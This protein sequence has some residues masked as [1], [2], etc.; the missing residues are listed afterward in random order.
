[1]QESDV[2]IISSY[3]LPDHKDS[4]QNRTRNNRWLSRVICNHTNYCK[5][6][7][8]DY[9][10]RPDSLSLP[11]KS[12]SLF[13][14]GANSK[15]GYILQA[16]ELG[17]KHVFWMDPD[18]LFCNLNRT[19]NDLIHSSSS[20]IASGDSHEIVNAGHLFF[21]SSE[22]SSLLLHAWIKLQD[23]KFQGCKSVAFD[24]T[25]EG[26]CVSDNT[27]L[28][29]LLAHGFEGI[30]SQSIVDS[31]NR[32]NGYFANPYA[33]IDKFSNTYRFHSEHNV[34]SP[35]PALASSL[36]DYVSILPQRRLNSYVLYGDRY[37]YLRSGDPIVHF[38]GPDKILLTNPALYTLYSLCRYFHVLF[39]FRALYLNLYNRLR[40]IHLSL[41]S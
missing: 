19:L 29:A 38:V 10:F 35:H 36:W 12:E 11:S 20:L 22:E 31:F 28:V 16:F 4:Y 39:L 3:L 33:D 5:R 14:K 24:L 30:C 32:V 26:Y 27:L 23:L 13:Y 2:C 9:I 6:H 25:T 7:G 34:Q 40:F 8:Y 37:S 1:M 17:Y 21:N 41:K 15:P 18:S